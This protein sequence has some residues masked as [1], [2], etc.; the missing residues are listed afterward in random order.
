MILIII[1]EHSLS[2]ENMKLIYDDKIVH[3]MKTPLELYTYGLID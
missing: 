3:N 1:L 2:I